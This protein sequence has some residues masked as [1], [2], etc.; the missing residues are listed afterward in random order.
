VS[1][2]VRQAVKLT[3]GR[4][5]LLTQE[6]T[7]SHVDVG[8]RVSRSLDSGLALWS[9]ADDLPSPSLVSAVIRYNALSL[10]MSMHKV[11]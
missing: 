10:E 1:E 2:G 8:S 9:D 4:V 6:I 7:N 3:S 11:F 5:H